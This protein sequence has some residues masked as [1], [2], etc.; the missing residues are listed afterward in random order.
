MPHQPWPRL[1]P[2]EITCKEI[3]KGYLLSVQFVS[4]NLKICITN[5]YCPSANS[6]RGAFLYKLAE[7]VS[8]IDL[9]MLLAGGYPDPKARWAEPRSPIGRAKRRRVFLRIRTFAHAVRPF[10]LKRKLGGR[11]RHSSRR[12][13]AAGGRRRSRGDGSWVE[14]DGGGMMLA[15]E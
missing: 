2:S 14:E 15:R 11:F 4:S 8:T 10:S 12:G 3:Y 5:V 9:T 6:E 7:F 13:V 1:Q